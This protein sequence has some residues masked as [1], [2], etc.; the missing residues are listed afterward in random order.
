[1]FLL[2]NTISHVV[3]Y[4]CIFNSIYNEFTRM[5]RSQKEKCLKF[6]TEADFCLY[7]VNI[8]SLYS[9]K[10]KQKSLRISQYF[11]AHFL[12]FT[13]LKTFKTHFFKIFIIHKPSLGSREVSHKIWA[14]SEGGE[15]RRSDMEGR[16]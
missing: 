10:Q 15:G 6:L 5:N 2:R 12:N 4:F 8:F 7:S 9:I 16:E 1:M 13:K 14:R 3:N 11:L